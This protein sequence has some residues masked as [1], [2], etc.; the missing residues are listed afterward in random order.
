MPDMMT[1]ER[2]SDFLSRKMEHL[3]DLL[4]RDMTP[5]F[6][7]V[8]YKPAWW[9]SREQVRKIIEGKAFKPSPKPKMEKFPM[10]KR[11]DEI[12]PDMRAMQEAINNNLGK[13][14]DCDA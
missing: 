12:F 7:A 1:P 6:S 9:V 3:D 14:C 13:P 4:L 5:P 11:F 2:F 8:E 10:P